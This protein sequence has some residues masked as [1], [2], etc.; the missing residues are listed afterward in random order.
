M[1]WNK[2][3]DVFGLFT[4][5]GTTLDGGWDCG[6]VYG[7]YTEANLMQNI[8]KEAVKILR[9][10][11]IKVLSDSDKGNNANMVKTVAMANKEKCKY[12][13]SVHCDYSGASA[14]VYPLYTSVEG[15][16]LAVSVGKYVA[17]E[18]GMKY[19]GACK[20]TDLYELNAT[21]M[22]ACIFETG[23]IKADLK[24]LKAHKKYGESFAHGIMK[25]LGVEEEKTGLVL[26]KRG[27]YKIGDD[28]DGVRAVQQWLKDHKFG[29][30]KVDGIYGV[31]TATAVRKFQKKY[32][33]EQDGLFGPECLAKANTIS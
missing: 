32:K 27:Y 23:A 15:K 17:K 9:A 10:S 22:P 25:F 14:G 30:D 2:K 11:G 3:K 6:C 8:T 4:G 20:R 21:N 19:K 26:P 16:K 1:S 18:M 33:L 5:H 13:M 12:Y 28:G 24:N 29:P 31:K 7:I